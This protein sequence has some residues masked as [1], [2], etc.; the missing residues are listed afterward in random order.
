VR[1]LHSLYNADGGFGNR[2]GWPSNPVATFYAIT[3][4]EHLEALA[5][6]PD[7]SARG[8]LSARRPAP[9]TLPPDLK[10]FTA[11]IEEMNRAAA[12][13][14]CTFAAMFQ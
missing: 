13:S 6:R 2:P 5:A 3:A 10:L 9:D 1:Y 7:P 11:Q 14:G 4:L 12:E 8:L